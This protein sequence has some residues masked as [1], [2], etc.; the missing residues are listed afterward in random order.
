[1][2]VH[3]ADLN[4]MGVLNAMPMA[5]RIGDDLFLNH[6]DLPHF[7]DKFD[8]GLLD[9]DHFV[10]LVGHFDLDLLHLLDGG[11]V[12]SVD[13]DFSLNG[14]VH[15]RFGLFGL[16]DGLVHHDDLGNQEG[17]V[18]G[19]DVGDFL[20]PCVDFVDGLEDKGVDF[21]QCGDGL[22]AGGVVGLGD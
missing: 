4:S 5:W 1:M 17:D 9:L 20:D 14:F 13:H 2:L 18:L 10:D 3:L 19:H 7:P 15:P 6:G 8:N 12:G 16:L 22:H 21:L 11:L